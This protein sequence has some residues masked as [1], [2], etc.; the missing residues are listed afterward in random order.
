M[1]MFIV[2]NVLILVVCIVLACKGWASFV[3]S[4]KMLQAKQK[5]KEDVYAECQK[6]FYLR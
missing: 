1:E 6:L 4:R 5:E 3:K 2:I